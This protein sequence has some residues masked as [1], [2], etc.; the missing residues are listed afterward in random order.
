MNFADENYDN[1]DKKQQKKAIEE[2]KDYTLSQ[3]QQLE[4]IGLEP[5][6]LTLYTKTDK[7]VYICLCG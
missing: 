5:A 7:Q 2:I 1:L 4:Q 3:I 6:T